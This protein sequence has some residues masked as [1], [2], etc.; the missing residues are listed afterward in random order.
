MKLAD[1][2]SKQQ[3]TMSKIQIAWGKECNQP[4]STLKNFK[5]L[6]KAQPICINQ[7]YYNSMDNRNKNT[8]NLINNRLKVDSTHSK[9][10]AR[11]TPSI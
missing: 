10:E 2:S 9:T 3:L 8:V 4:K 7:Y 5:T 11:H 1:Q 6:T